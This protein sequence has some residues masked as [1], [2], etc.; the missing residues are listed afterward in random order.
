MVTGSTIFAG[1]V[2]LGL[3][4]SQLTAAPEVRF[5]PEVQLLVAEFIDVDELD[6]VPV[7]PRV[8]APLSGSNRL[9]GTVPTVYSS[10]FTG[11]IRWNR[12]EGSWVDLLDASKPRAGRSSSISGIRFG[13]VD[14]ID[15]SGYNSALFS[16]KSGDQVEPDG[17]ASDLGS[18]LRVLIVD[19]EDGGTAEFE[20]RDLESIDF[21][22]P[23]STSPTESRLFGT[24]TT[25]SGMH[26]TGHVT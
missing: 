19:E 21:S 12:N 14:R 13:H 15:V 10:K 22:E 23:R 7:V 9:Y 25:Q 18:G 2:P 24:L 6:P 1:L 16:L 8:T 4:V 26:F 17:N 3:L 5:G 20:W 11:Y